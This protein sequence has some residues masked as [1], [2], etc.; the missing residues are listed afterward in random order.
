M[1]HVVI[2]S[3]RIGVVGVRESNSQSGQAYLMRNS[4]WVPTGTLVLHLYPCS[5]IHRL[6]QWLTA[7]PSSLSHDS[8]D[9]LGYLLLI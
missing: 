9:K 5:S 1:S 6:S 7:F 4:D 3:G 2:G 8:T